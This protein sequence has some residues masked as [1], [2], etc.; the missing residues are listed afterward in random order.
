ML[1]VAIEHKDTHTQEYIYL[2]F[3]TAIEKF[4]S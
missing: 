1:N 3:L 2:I 4:R